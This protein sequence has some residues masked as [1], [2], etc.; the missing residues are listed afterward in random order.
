MH[1]APVYSWS[2]TETSLRITLEGVA[3]KDQGQLFCSD[4]LVKL[5]APP[6]LLL[7]DLHGAIDEERSSAIVQRGRRLVLQ[8]HK[9][10]A[11]LVAPPPLRRSPA[12]CRPSACCALNRHLPLAARRPSPACGAAW[13]Q[14]AAGRSSRRRGRSRCSAHTPSSWRRRR[15]APSASSARPGEQ[16]GLC[17][18]LCAGLLRRAR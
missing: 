4:R 9:V 17:A 2:E 14:A 12:C 7:L 16:P 5:N 10:P 3:L 8:L 1:L 13:W 6:H 18:G 15:S 11:L